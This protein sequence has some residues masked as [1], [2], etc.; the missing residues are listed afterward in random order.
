MANKD[1]DAAFYEVYKYLSGLAPFTGPYGA[2]YANQNVFVDVAGN[3]NVLSGKGQGLTSGFALLGNQYQSPIT[4]ANPCA[5]TY[6]IYI[7]NNANNSGSNGQAAYESSV[8]N[9]NPALPIEPPTGARLR[10]IHGRTSGPIFSRPTA[11]SCPRQ[12]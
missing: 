11:S 5:A 8:A 6:I 4:T 10:S 3:P 1:E 12:Q 7:A 9:A 2:S